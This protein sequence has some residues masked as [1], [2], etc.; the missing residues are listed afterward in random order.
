MSTK[1]KKKKKVEFQNIVWVM[2]NLTVKQLADH[3][4]KPY[5]GQDIL[6]K[7]TEMIEADFK[8]STKFDDY[9]QCFLATA[10]CD[11]ADATNAGLAISSRGQDIADVLSLLLYK[12]FNVAECDLKTFADK[13]PTGVRG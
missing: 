12:F 3:D 10:I 9:N 13:M 4:A 6:H 8:I 7:M 5:E 2:D 11:N 1:S